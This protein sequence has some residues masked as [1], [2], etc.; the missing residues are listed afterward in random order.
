MVCGRE[1]LGP[2]NFQ[3]EQV[4][5]PRVDVAGWLSL[6]TTRRLF[7]AAGEDFDVLKR[8][9]VQQEF[10]PVPLH[11]RADIRITNELRRIVSRNVVGIR[12]GSDPALA[13][14]GWF[15][16]RIGIIWERIRVSTATVFST[17]A[18][19]TRPGL[20]V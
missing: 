8:R 18:W 5:G 19:T 12:A 4:E 16:P 15:T 17:G 9:A 10:R 3:L 20:P 6:E 2:E 13:N 14:V 7:S 11:A 1:F